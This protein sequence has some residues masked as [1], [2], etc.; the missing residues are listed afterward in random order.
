VRRSGEGAA[1]EALLGGV[2]LALGLAC[3]DGPGSAQDTTATADGTGSGTESGSSTDLGVCRPISS[4]VMDGP[5]EQILE[6]VATRAQIPGLAEQPSAHGQ[7]LGTLYAFD[8]RL[9]LGYGDYSDNTGPIRMS[10]WDPELSTFVDLGDLPT[11]EVLWF[12]A[13][14]HA[15]YT[16][17]VDADGHQAD[18]GVYRLDCGTEAWTVGPAIEGAVHVYDVALQGDYVYVGTGSLSGEPALVLRSPDRGQSWEEVLRL[19]TG[20][21]EYARFYYLGATPQLLFTSAR[22]LPSPGPSLAWRSVGE[23][24]LEPLPDPPDSPLVPVVLG[25]QMVLT[26]F[27]GN[28]GR[29]SYRASFRLDGET[30]VPEAPW[31]MDEAGGAALVAWAPQPADGDQPER[32]LV[33]TRAPDGQASVHRSADLWAGPDAWEQL[34]VLEARDDDP[35]VSM[36]LLLNTLYLGTKQGSLYALRQLEQPG[37]DG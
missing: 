14:E 12:Q 19:Q 15:L 11:E 36:A 13:S 2:V 4:P 18:G 22:V 9:H 20:A 31:P 30:F 21:D 35:F 37:L 5:G 28:P 1:T 3:G 34:A 10:A 7:I 25:S 23:G 6:R 17:A 33:L 16:T 32:L 29:G 26:D 24:P 8:G 27:S